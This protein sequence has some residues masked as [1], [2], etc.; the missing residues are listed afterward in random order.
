MADA[1]AER[2]AEIWR[3]YARGRRQ[4]DIARQYGVT[5]GAISQAIARHRATIP[6]ETKDEI[7]KRE[8]DLLTSLR[9]EVLALWHD[10]NGAPVTAGKDGDIV[11]DPETNEVVR[12]HSGRLAAIRAA[13]ELSE[14]IARITGIDA[15]L[16]VDLG[17]AEQAE[18]EA[19]AAEAL[20]HL[21]GGTGD[22]A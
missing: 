10:T 17:R 22:D 4:S 19:L 8:I 18:S 6:D 21:H 9:D 1:Q 7:A 14:R 13:R 20:G 5:Q 3:L 11:R 16:R 15:A 12:D 2:D